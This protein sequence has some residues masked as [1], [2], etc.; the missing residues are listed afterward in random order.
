[1]ALPTKCTVSAM[2]ELHGSTECATYLGVG[3]SREGFLE[4]GTSEWIP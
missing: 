3:S 4:E 1:M 2:R